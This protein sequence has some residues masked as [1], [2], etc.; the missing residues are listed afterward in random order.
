MPFLGTTGGGSVKQYGGQANLG[1]FIKNSLR[2]R[3][4]NN[5]YLSRAQG[6]AT[7]TTT[8]TWSGWIKRGSLS[9]TQ[10]FWSSSNYDFLRWKSDDKIEIAYLG[11]AGYV[12]TYAVYRDPA[13]WYHVV[14]VFDTTNGTAVNRMRLYVN[15]VEQ[16]L[17]WGATPQTQNAVFQ[18]WN[19]SGYTGHLGNFQYDNSD[20]LDGYMAECYW[21]DGQALTP[22]SFGKTDVGTNQWIPKKYLGTYGNNG[23][24]LKFADT[25]AATAAAIGKDSSG[26][27]N[28]WTPNNIN[29]SSTT[30]I[31]SYTT[32]GTST[33]IAPLGVT[34]VNYLVVA[35]GGAGGS[36]GPT[37]YDSGSGGG[38]AGGVANGSL[39]IV[40]G[41]S[42]TLTVGTAGAG[43]SGRTRGANGSNSVFATITAIGG[44]GGAPGAAA[45]D[46]AAGGSGGGSS[47]SGAGGAGTPG[48]GFAGASSTT[49]SGGGGGGATAAAIASPN[50]RGGDGG[51]GFTSSISGS[52]VTYGGGGGG[53]A[54]SGSP[55]PGGSGGSSIGG[56]GGTNNSNGS[57]AT[58]YGSGGGGSGGTYNTTGTLSGGSGSQGIVI[59]S[60]TS[61]TSTN[62]DA[63]IDSPTRSA[64]ASNYATLNPLAKRQ[65]V[66]TSVT[67]ADGNLK[68]TF[69]DAGGNQTHAWGT[70]TITSG[71]CYW[72]VTINATPS[73]VALGIGDQTDLDGTANHSVIYLQDG[74]IA[75]YGSTQTT[76]ATFTTNDVIGIAYDASS[77]TLAYY[78]NG[79]LQYTVT[80]LLYIPSLPFH[81]GTTSD[82]IIV[83]FGQRPFTYTPPS[84]FKSLNTFNL[85]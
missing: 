64:V 39:V 66:T 81:R 57:N 19:V 69:P 37:M 68:A 58:G 45:N 63:M 43:T 38:G 8:G 82:S 28:N 20:I 56:A 21:I 52:P 77:A 31:K 14:L 84:G 4:A 36:A 41:T 70:Q 30:A 60:Y 48:Q 75:K 13:A 15:G 80:G 83:N 34:A 26:N 54:Y 76:A 59:L 11:N 42:Y 1:Y 16:T 40:P 55:G 79:V 18:R 53:G 23:F 27:G 73:N 62:Y 35:G 51:A 2:F 67:F 17:N 72:E 47:T 22:S 85:P 24:Y 33:W 61:P 6:T 44:G 71:K 9:S 5:N 65:D 32:T 78:K 46:G 25:S 50:N 3:R 29:V 10:H 7:S 74:T 12:E 49:S